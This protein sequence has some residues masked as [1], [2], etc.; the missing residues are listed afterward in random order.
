MLELI[1]KNA[2]EE[3][4]LNLGKKRT[5]SSSSQARTHYE[6]GEFYDSDDEVHAKT[7]EEKNVRQNIKAKIQNKVT[8]ATEKINRKSP[9]RKRRPRVE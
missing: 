1:F 3:L 4:N 6:V 9:S 5:S 2:E 8:Q 7:R